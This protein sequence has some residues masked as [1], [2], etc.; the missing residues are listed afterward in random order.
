M[1][2]TCESRRDRQ[3]SAALVALWA[4]F[5]LRAMSAETLSD[6]RMD[7]LYERCYQVREARR[8]V[9]AQPHHHSR[10]PPCIRIVQVEVAENDEFVNALWRRVRP[11]LQRSLGTLTL[12]GVPKLSQTELAELDAVLQ[13]EVPS[14]RRL[15][16]PSAPATH[17][18]PPPPPPQSPSPPRQSCSAN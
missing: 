8:A 10:P 7:A 13:T 14:L 11:Q 12:A 18:P 15:A 6:K 5:S 1:M 17:E 16:S 9:W 2:M 4:Q 3:V